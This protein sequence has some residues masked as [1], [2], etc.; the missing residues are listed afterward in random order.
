M[1][2]EDARSDLSVIENL[3]VPTASGATVPLSSV[4]TIEFGAGPAT[5]S[6]QDRARVAS[7]TAELDGILTG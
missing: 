6:R 5:V 1:L 3:R 4:A 2:T 7:I